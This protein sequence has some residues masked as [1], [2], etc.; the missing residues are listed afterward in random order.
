MQ[1]H[2]LQS[3]RNGLGKFGKMIEWIKKLFYNEYEVR[4]WHQSNPD[5]KAVFNLIKITKKSNTKIEGIDTNKKPFEYCS[6]EPFNYQIRK[7]H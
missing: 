7:K 6:P 1:M 3:L 5:Q 2:P 4:V